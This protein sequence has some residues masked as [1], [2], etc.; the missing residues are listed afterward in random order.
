VDSEDDA[1]EE[2]SLPEYPA[3]CIEGDA[4]SDFV[5]AVPIARNQQI[6]SPQMLLVGQ[7]QGV[8]R[9]CMHLNMH[10]VEQSQRN[11]K[12]IDDLTSFPAPS[13]IS[14]RTRA[15]LVTDSQSTHRGCQ[16]WLNVGTSPFVTRS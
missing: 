3:D 2:A 15:M 1:I 8:R 6:R 16:R 4:I 9:M 12:S 7:N 10:L 11:G 14:G 13:P 5:H